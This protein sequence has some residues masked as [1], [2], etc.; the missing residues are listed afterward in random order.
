MR[1]SQVEWVDYVEKF[2][3]RASPTFNRFLAAMACKLDRSLRHL[4]VDQVF[5]QSE[6]Y[7]GIYLRLPPGCGPIYWK[8]IL[9]NK[10][11]YSLMLSGRASHYL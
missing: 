5:I 7:I 1:F 10:A 9:L 3:T 2:A 8:A 6:L 11:L 4:D